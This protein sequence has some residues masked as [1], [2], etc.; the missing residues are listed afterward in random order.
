MIKKSIHHNY[1]SF[2]FFSVAYLFSATGLLAQQ[3]NPTAPVFE[4]KTGTPDKD[5]QLFRSN[6]EGIP[7]PPK[8]KVRAMAEWEEL[9]AIAL[10]WSSDWAQADY[11]TL[12]AEITL[13]AR[14]ECNVNILCDDIAAI[15]QHLQN[16]VGITDYTLP[17]VCP[18]GDLG[19]SQISFIEVDGQFDRRIWIRDYAAHTIYTNDVDTM[20]FVDWIYDGNFVGADVY[21]SSTVAD[22]Y[23]TPLYVTTQNEYALRLDGGNFLTDGMGN[24]FS[25][26]VVVNE[27]N[28]N[29][30]PAQIAKEFMGIDTYHYQE[31]P[32]L[33]H[34]P[35]A[36]KHVDMYMKLLDEETILLGEGYPDDNENANRLEDYLLYFNNLETPHNRSYQVERIIIPPDENGEYPGVPNTMSCNVAGSSCF[37]NYTNALFINRS[38]L[39]PTYNNEYDEEALER[40]RSLMPGYKIIGINS[41]EIIKRNGAIHCVTKEI[42]VKDPLWIT[43]AKIREAC[44]DQNKYDVYAKIQHLSGIEKA[45]VFYTAN[46]NNGFQSVDMHPRDNHGF[47]AEIPA[48]PIGTTV[49]YYVEAIAHSGKKMVRP[50]PAPQGYWAFTVNDCV[51]SGQDHIELGDY[52]IDIFPNPAKNIVSIST[53][54]PIATHTKIKLRDLWGRTIAFV[55]QGQVRNTEQR[56]EVD[57]TDIPSGIYFVEIEVDQMK[58]TRKLVTK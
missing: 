13:H 18:G 21:P 46:L 39:V 10:A 7:V 26:R 15:Q 1:I 25:S 32:V 4:Q 53:Q 2:I 16:I 38:I 28:Q 43:H 34:H 24:A 31:L 56:F 23:E 49:Y 52:Q 9:E 14:Q 5:L 3:N 22:F 30:V 50:M 37:L 48:Y 55:Y 20:A 35:G 41:S 8:S 27:N 33:L 57:I 11:D 40:W 29:G 17:I 45:K 47:K 19:T 51:Q 6:T 44:I 36:R 58:Y 42:G 54:I 12:L